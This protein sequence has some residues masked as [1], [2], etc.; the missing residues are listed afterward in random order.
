MTS[1]NDVSRILAFIDPNDMD[2]DFEARLLQTDTAQFSAQLAVLERLAERGKNV[3]E[4]Q[5]AVEDQ[6]SSVKTRQLRRS[7]ILERMEGAMFA[8]SRSITR[9][10]VQD[11][12][13]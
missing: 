1:K 8:V 6:E 5:N 9:S 13:R 3:R 7:E 2:H 10:F 11:I 12:E 4:A